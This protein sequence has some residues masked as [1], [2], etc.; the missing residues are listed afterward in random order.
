M[1]ATLDP[2]CWANLDDFKEHLD[3]DATDTSKDNFLTNVLN[4]AWK[5]AVN[6][7]GYDLTA[8][9]YIEYYDGDASDTILLD[10]YPIISIASIYED[11]S[12][13]FA[14][15]TLIAATDYVFYEKTGKVQKV[16]SSTGYVVVGIPVSFSVFGRGVQNVK[17]SYRAGY[18]SIPY[19][20]NRAVILLGAWYA[21]R[22]GTEG[23]TAETLGGKTVQYDN[24]SI[25]LFIRQLL[26]PYKKFSS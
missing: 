20:A 7:I 17:V 18:S 5:A 8:T 6:Y 3:I 19:D 21:Q 2:A 4:A 14:S 12:R 25:P 23:K 9:D 1:P 13:T 26:L 15:D 24:Y 22:A 10:N 11:I 16:P